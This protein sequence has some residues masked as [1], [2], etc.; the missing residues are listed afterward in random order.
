[1]SNSA[2]LKQT[3]TPLAMG[4]DIQV[5]QILYQ[6]EQ[7]E[8]LFL[9]T[10][11]YFNK[12]LGLYFENDVILDLYRRGK[13]I[14]DYFGVLSWKARLKNHINNTYLKKLL[15]YG[16]DMFSLTYDRHDV[17][18]YGD[19]CHPGFSTIYKELLEELKLDPDI[20]PAIGLYQ[21][22]IIARPKIYIDYI[23]N[24]LIP[25][26]DFFDNCSDEINELLYADANYRGVNKERLSKSFGV[27]HYTLHTFVL[28][29]L[30]SLY[31]HA[32]RRKDTISYFWVKINFNSYRSIKVNSKGRL[33]KFNL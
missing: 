29:R 17:F 1:M 14:G 23:E 26:L 31:Y 12:D 22:A 11:P 9:D 4:T 19:L 8:H 16:F 24:F 28:E 10:I 33:H 2:I 7:K 30:W 15:K 18:G 21:N 20:K 25:T 6:E 3:G 27:T 5:Y 32:R 13:I